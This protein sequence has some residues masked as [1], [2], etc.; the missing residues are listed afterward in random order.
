MIITVFCEANHSAGLELLCQART[1]AP[2]AHIAALHEDGDAEKYVRCGADEAIFLE[3]AAD[4]CAQ[5]SRI[6]ETLRRQEPD[7]ALFPATVRGRF[8]SAWAAAKLKTGLT[9]D[10]TG[11]SITEGGL[12]KQTRPA[13]GGN[14]TADILCPDRRPQMASVRPGVFPLPPAGPRPAKALARTSACPFPEPIMK[15]LNAI[16]SDDPQPLQQAKVIVAGGK[17]VGSKEGF[18]LLFE[19]AGLLGGAVGATRSAVDAGWV[20]Y[21]HQIG[22]TG[23][24]VRPTLYLAFGI[25]GMV[26]HLAGM[27]GAGTVLAVNTDRNAPIFQAADFGIVA[28][29]RETAEYMIRFIKERKDRE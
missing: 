21:A 1:M 3:P 13:Y 15:L 8:L 27:R 5:G 16:P 26:Q 12:L 14:L 22:Q 9:A 17:G 11:L 25:S 20:S 10:C 2:Q 6:A 28:P 23:V 7:I 24:T 19:L 29:W 4:D 18:S